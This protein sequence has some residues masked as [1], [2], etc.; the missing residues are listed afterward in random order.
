MKPSSTTPLIIAAVI[1]LSTISFAK[2]TTDF[3]KHANFT[4]NLRARPT[5]AGSPGMPG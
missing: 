3:D 1:V 2:V 4:R 5:R